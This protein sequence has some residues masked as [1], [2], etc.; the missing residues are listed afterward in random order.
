MFWD[1]S[2]VKVIPLSRHCWQDYYELCKPRVVLLMLVTSVVG[3][4]LATDEAIPL[5]QL[6]GAN[7]GIGCIASAAA[8]INHLADQHIDRLMG[9]TQH[10]PLAQYRVTLSQVLSFAFLLCVMGSLLLLYYANSLT[11][12]LTLGSLVGYAGIYTICLKYVTPQNIVIGGL[13]GAAP[14]LLGWTAIT[15]TIDP[16]A[17][18]LV[19]IIFVWTPPHFWA[20]AIARYEDYA[21]AA[22]PMLPNT[23]SIRYTKWHIVLYTLLLT[24][25]T[26]LPVATGMATWAY[27]SAI[28]I[29]NLR[30]L[31]LVSHLYRDQTSSRAMEIFWYSILYLGLLFLVLLLDHYWLIGV[32]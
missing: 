21:N 30:F 22:I 2:M 19:L 24:V 20:L 13:S 15:G 26:L 17:L 31:Y 12:G 1:D 11:L 7:L 23:H 32:Y 18:L 4:C 8:A 14:P 3:M 28:T 5:N 29:L 10:R 6:I 27:G 16:N 25:V 9:R